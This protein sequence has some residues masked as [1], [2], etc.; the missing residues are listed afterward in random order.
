MEKAIYK[1]LEKIKN[2]TLSDCLFIGYTACDAKCIDSKFGGLPYFPSDSEYPVNEAG[3]PLYFLAQINF[4]QL[5]AQ[6]LL[7]NKGMLQFFIDGKDEL[8]G[9][10]LED[11]KQARNFRVIFHEVVDE[12]CHCELPFF[13]QFDGFDYIEM[14]DD[15]L[16]SFKNGK[17]YMSLEDYRFV[18]LFKQMTSYTMREADASIDDLYSKYLHEFSFYK[19][20]ILGYPVFLQADFRVDE[21]D[22]DILLFQAVASEEL[23]FAWGDC[24]VM[25]FFISETDLRNRDFSKVSFQFDV[26]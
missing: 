1:G 16:M 13:E 14:V 22:M 10:N 21:D 23:Q 11:S 20:Q 26:C 15:Y 12:S 24:G 19:N 5:P 25:N 3:Y 6:D 4:E 17:Q 2:D 8:L 7:P 18:S 9:I